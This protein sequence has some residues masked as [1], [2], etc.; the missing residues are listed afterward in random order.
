MDSLEV[1]KKATEKHTR[2]VS[3]FRLAA[4]EMAKTDKARAEQLLASA[5]S[6]H[7]AY[8]Q[9]TR[10]MAASIGKGDLA[11]F[12]GGLYPTS[13]PKRNADGTI[14]TVYVE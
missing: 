8:Q 10:Q 1:W 13:Y 5:D 12:L 9:Y 6:V 2:E 11:D 7:R 14:D 4:K 3:S